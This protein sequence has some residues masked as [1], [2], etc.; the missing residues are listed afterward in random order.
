MMRKIN[1]PRVSP[2]ETTPYGTCILRIQSHYK[3]FNPAQKN[4]ADYILSNRQ[5]LPDLD[6]DQLA[7]GAL[8]SG[9]TVTRFCRA[10]GFPSFQ[11]FK[12]ESVTPAELPPGIGGNAISKHL[13]VRQGPFWRTPIFQDG[14]FFRPNPLERKN[15][16]ARI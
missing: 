1:N 15:L 4:L 5:A 13:G 3:G 14:D 10:I 12:I 16:T 7:K 11:K 2:F 6:L 9:A 8:V